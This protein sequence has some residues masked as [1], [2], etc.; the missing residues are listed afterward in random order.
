MAKVDN[1]EVRGVHSRYSV[2]RS[3]RNKDRR[4]CV[5]IG[6]R[7]QQVALWEDGPDTTLQGGGDID[8]RH[9]MEEERGWWV[10]A[11]HWAA[12]KGRRPFVRILT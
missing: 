6:H 5:D 8:D 1:G 10:L 12:V 4:L 11:T 7:S 9:G 2:Q 3:S